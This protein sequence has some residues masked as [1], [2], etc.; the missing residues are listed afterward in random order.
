MTTEATKWCTCIHPNHVPDFILL[1]S[2]G[3][4]KFNLITKIGRTHFFQP[5]SNHLVFK[6]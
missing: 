4:E 3:T 2:D 1:K 6:L 5:L